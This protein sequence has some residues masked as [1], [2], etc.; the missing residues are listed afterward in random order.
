MT[1]ENEA[2]KG[3]IRMYKDD[4]EGSSRDGRTCGSKMVASE[5]LQFFIRTGPGEHDFGPLFSSKLL[6]GQKVRHGAH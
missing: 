2:A 1:D 5:P 6:V 4:A 3:S